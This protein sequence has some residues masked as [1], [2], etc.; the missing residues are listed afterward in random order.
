M[1]ASVRTVY[2]ADAD[3]DTYVP[4]DPSRDG[5]WV[6]LLVGPEGGEGEE[7]FDRLICTPL[8]LRDVIAREGPQFGRHHLIIDP[9][10][11]GLAERVLRRKFE[12]MEAEDWPSLGEKLSR[13]GYWEFED[14]QP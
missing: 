5:L 6:H 11:L 9:F 13:L 1:R 12:S 2:S 7:S 14:Y 8:W 3:I 10:D 4:E